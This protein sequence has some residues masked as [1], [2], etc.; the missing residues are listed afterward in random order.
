VI[1]FDV[2]VLVYAHREDAGDH[3]DYRARL[4]RLVN[5][6]EAFGLA[7]IVLSG[8][9]RIVTH[10]R[11]FASATPMP[12]ALRFVEVLRS[13]PNAVPVAPGARHWEIFSNLCRIPGT[14]GNHIPDAFLAALAIESGSEWLTTDR[15]F[16][17][18]A[19]LRW[20]HPL[21]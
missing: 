2:N 18:F 6:A 9:L 1:L 5:G 16:A 15:G 11:I 12:Q 4:E 8:F 7:D 14:R 20:R 21:D 17:R 10:P 13:R 19:G 3:A